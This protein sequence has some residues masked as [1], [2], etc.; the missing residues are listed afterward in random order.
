MCLIVF[1]FFLCFFLQIYDYYYE[2]Y[3]Q[4]M[5]IKP[6]IEINRC[7]VTLGNEN[8]MHLCDFLLFKTNKVIIKTIVTS[9]T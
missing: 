9:E 7:L 6:C 2:L 3:I 4:L 5:E 8:S 1:L